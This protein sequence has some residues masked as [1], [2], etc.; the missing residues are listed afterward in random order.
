LPVGKNKTFST[1]SGFGDHVLGNWQFNTILIARSGQ[2]FTVGATGDIANIGNGNTYVRGLV[3]G[4]PKPQNPS[5]SQWFNTAAFGLP[6]ATVSKAGIINEDPT[7][8]EGNSPRNNL[9]D[10]NYYNFDLSVF[11]PFSIA[12]P[13]YAEF[14]AEAFNVLNHTVLGTPNTAINAPKNAFGTITS[15]AST[16]RL[17]QFALRLTF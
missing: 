4:N 14:R 10:Q 13:L 3:L 9:Q 15:T 5:A 8:G 11:K 6:F 16:E 1:H 7:I 12:E 17:L 2:N